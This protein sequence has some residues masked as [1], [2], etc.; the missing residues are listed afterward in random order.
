MSMNI[1]SVA[2]LYVNDCRQLKEVGREMSGYVMSDIGGLCQWL[3]YNLGGGC[4]LTV[5]IVYD[6]S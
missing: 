4:Q 3:F 6:R 2:I 5:V 1:P